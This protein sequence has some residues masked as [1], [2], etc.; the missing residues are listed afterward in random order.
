MKKVLL[1]LTFAVYVFA[2]NVYAQ[3]GVGVSPPRVELYATPGGQLT[4]EIEVDNPSD[5]SELTVTSTLSDALFQPDGSVLYLPGGSHPN[6]LA[7]W[8]TI[9]PIQFDLEPLI[10]E[11]VRYT[12]QVP[13]AASEGT[14]WSVILFESAAPQ[15]EAPTQAGVGVST[16][17]RIGHVIYVD[18]GNVTHDGVITGVRY[19]ATETGGEVRVSFQNTGNGLVRLSGQLE[20]RDATG[21]LV[22]TLDVQDEAALPGYTREIAAAL[23]EPLPPGDYVALAVLDYGEAKVAAGEGSFQIP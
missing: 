7:D 16:L 17:V 1:L 21:N 2:Q 12:V 10:A 3:T 14:Y 18:V 8:L 11:T 4:Q 19:Q 9:T 13:Q 15:S 23:A 20:L 22:Q 6:S 5:F